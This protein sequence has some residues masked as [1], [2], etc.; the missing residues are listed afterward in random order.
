MFDASDDDDDVVVVGGGRGLQSSYRP[1][2]RLVLRVFI[3]TN[4]SFG[5]VGVDD[6]SCFGSISED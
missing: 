6:H 4:V 1:E 3:Y 2:T 5:I